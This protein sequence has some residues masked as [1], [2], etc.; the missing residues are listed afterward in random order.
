M[1]IKVMRII[2]LTYWIEEEFDRIKKFIESAHPIFSRTISNEIEKIIRLYPEIYRET[3]EKL[4]EKSL[5]I[6]KETKDKINAMKDDLLNKIHIK[7][8]QQSQ[9][10]MEKPVIGCDTS[11]NTLPIATVKMYAISGISVFVKEREVKY[12][13][14]LTDVIDSERVVELLGIPLESDILDGMITDEHTEFEDVELRFIVSAL[15]EAYLCELARKHLEELMEK[16]ENIYAVI[17]DGPLSISQ[18]YEKVPGDIR[19]RAVQVL[20]NARNDLMDV[21][22]K[23]EV[24][25]LGVVK[26][27]RGRYFHH[28][29]DMDELSDFSDQ[30]LFHQI[31]NYCERTETLSITEGIRKWRK[32]DELKRYKKDAKSQVKLIEKRLEEKIKTDILLINRLNYEILGFFIKSSPDQ[33]TQPIRIEFPH[34]L[35]S[36]DD[37][38]ASFVV[39]TSMR[40]QNPAY[41]DGLPFAIA[42][43]HIRAK[44]SSMLMCE[45]YGHVLVRIYQDF[46]DLRILP[47]EWGERPW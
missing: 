45:I 21:C 8:V 47:P 20:I 28:L 29:L 40:C 36:R 25:L 2:P 37:E 32:E 34:Y 10:F 42:I 6:A 41:I 9:N 43:P 4:I 13:K 23:A 14:A 7:K 39:S 3:K 24:L 15:R 26:R 18:W 35:K 31:L 33:L 16:D 44:L 19:K 46:K 12:V 11:S 17:I 5:K 30:A 22:K 27:G 1:K 38:I